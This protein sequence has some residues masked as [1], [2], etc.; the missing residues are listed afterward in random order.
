[1]TGDYP[2]PMGLEV[3]LSSGDLVMDLTGKWAAN[4]EGDINLS[5]GTT[6]LVFPTDVD[7]YV[8]A[9]TDSGD[10]S[11]NGLTRDGDAYVNEPYEVSHVTLRLS[12]QASS[13]DINLRLAE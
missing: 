6:T 11:A 12:V 10:I 1:M 4:L 8:E 3:D 7:V 5:S 9:E 13:G 2:S